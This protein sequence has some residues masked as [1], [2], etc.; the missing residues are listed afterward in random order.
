MKQSVKI[1]PGSYVPLGVTER[2]EGG[3]LLVLALH[4]AGDE[5][6]GVGQAPILPD[7]SVFA[8]DPELG[9]RVG[10]QIAVEGAQA[11]ARRQRR[12]DAHLGRPRPPG[13]VVC[14]VYESGADVRA[15]QAPPVHGRRRR[16][17][18]RRPR[19]A[20]PRGVQPRHDRPHGGRH[21]VQ[22]TLSLQ[23]YITKII[24]K[25][26]L[27]LSNFD[28]LRLPVLFRRETCLIKI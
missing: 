8:G 15:Q 26:L 16:G 11:V 19:H 25:T 2:D 20:R 17:K 6:G 23:K 13:V 24:I 7:G 18:R 22:A 27:S 28:W 10:F 3:I 9:A 12:D 1:L 5:R 21:V 4:L 14:R